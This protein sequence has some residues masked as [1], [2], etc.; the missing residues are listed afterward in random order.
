MFT[1]PWPAEPSHVA[2]DRTLGSGGWEASGLQTGPQ[3]QT[4]PSPQPADVRAQQ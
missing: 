3:Q 2:W 1:G 4:L